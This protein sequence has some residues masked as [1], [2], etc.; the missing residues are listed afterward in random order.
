MRKKN[1]IYDFYIKRIL[2][3]TLALLA[4]IVLLPI[5]FLFSVIG[6]FTMKG[7]PF[8]FQKR[9]GKN[10]KIFKLIKFRTMSNAKDES[11]NLLPDSERLN[12]YGK[13]LRKASIDELPELFN[14]LKG[15]MSIVGPRPLAVEYLMYYNEEEK[16]RHNVR[17]GLTGL[18]QVNGRNAV[19]WPERFAYDLEYVGNVSFMNDVKIILKTI[20]TVLR[21][22]D[23][24]IRGTTSIIDFD[25]FREQQW[26]EE[27]VKQNSN[28]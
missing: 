26:N 2:D 7:N 11:G 20:G 12:S 8:F 5:Y 25:K 6:F 13:F 15:D 3:F 24:A 9:P 27:K 21:R 28:Y 23:V 17:P 22:K 18:A 4:I 19:N 1:N 14:I 10:E 16:K